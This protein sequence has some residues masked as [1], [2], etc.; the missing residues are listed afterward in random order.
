[1]YLAEFTHPNSAE[2]VGDLLIDAPESV[3]RAFALQHASIWGLELFSLTPATAQ[4]V[5]MHQSMQPA[6]LALI[7]A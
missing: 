2:L 1:M 7:P 5:Q 6:T 4:Q 3:A